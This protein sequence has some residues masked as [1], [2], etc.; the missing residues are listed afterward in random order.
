MEAD[1]EFT[2]TYGAGRGGIEIPP[3]DILPPVI[4]QEQ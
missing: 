3:I 2:A 4:G 1:H